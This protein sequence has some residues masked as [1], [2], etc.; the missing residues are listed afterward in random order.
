MS[1]RRARRSRREHRFVRAA[2]VK[3][4]PLMRSLGRP[5]REQVVTTRSDVLTTLEALDLSN[6]QVLNDILDRARPSSSAEIR[7][8]TT[9][10]RST[11]EHWGAGRRPTS[12]RRP[13]SCWGR[14]RRR[15]AW[16]TCSGWCSCSPSSN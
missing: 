13:A 11:C 14:R 3:S 2:L 5:N 9:S 6:G 1:T 16:P 12:W 10:R 7:K 8:L 15:R 4:D